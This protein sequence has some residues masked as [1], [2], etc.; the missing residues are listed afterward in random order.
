MTYVVVRISR[1]ARYLC[2]AIAQGYNKPAFPQSVY[3]RDHMAAREKAPLVPLSRSSHRLRA[4]VRLLFIGVFL[5]LTS[6]LAASL[7]FHR[8]A[9]LEDGR[10]RAEDLAFI[11]SDHFTRTASAIDTTLSQIALL[12]RTLGVSTDWPP[13]LQSARSG[14][15][16]VAIL[17]VTD[18][19]GV[20]VEST[21]AQILGESRA[22]LPLPP[23][24]RRARRRPDGGSAVARTG[25]RTMGHPARPQVGGCR[26]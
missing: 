10:R 24:V 4:S 17:A 20:I 5:I 21:V 12:H 9:A 22:D 26:G 15:A 11:L 19:N 25:Q 13:I 18:A 1:A 6:V 16:G 8:N 23:P 2:A 7:V 3:R 14:A